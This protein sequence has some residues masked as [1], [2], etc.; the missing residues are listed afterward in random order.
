[1]GKRP[2]ARVRQVPIYLMQETSP[3]FKKSPSST[4][5]QFQHKALHARLPKHFWTSSAASWLSAN[6]F[7]QVCLGR[8]SKKDSAEGERWLLRSIKVTFLSAAGKVDGRRSSC[9]AQLRDDGASEPEQM[10]N[11]RR[12][13]KLIGRDGSRSSGS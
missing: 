6:K 12:R 10:A 9:V 8:R 11:R 13:C 7:R 4:S 2:V 5:S 1:M 3:F